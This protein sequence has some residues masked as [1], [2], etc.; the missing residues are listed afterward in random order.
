MPWRCEFYDIENI[1]GY[2]S[3]TIFLYDNEKRYILDFGYDIEFS[4]LK[5][6]NCTNP[7]YNSLEETYTLD[8]ISEI[9]INNLALIRNEIINYICP[10]AD[11]GRR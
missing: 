9:Y 2:F 8:E 6:M 4:S 3:G 1:D 11:C 5:L 7:V 10:A